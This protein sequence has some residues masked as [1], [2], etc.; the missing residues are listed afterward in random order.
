MNEY[1]VLDT[2]YH[3]SN[4]AKFGGWCIQSKQKIG[5]TLDLERRTV[6]NIIDS[7]LIKGL[8]LREEATGFLRAADI[9][10]D[11]M[12]DKENWIIGKTDEN[13]F[14]SIKQQIKEIGGEKNAP[15]VQ[16]IPQVVKNLHHDGEKNAP[17]NN[18]IYI[19][20]KGISGVK[21]IWNNFA[22]KHSLQ[23]IARV[24]RERSGK[25]ATRQKEELFDI[26]KI[27][28]EAEKQPFLFG[29][30]D[31]GW[32]MDFD[33]LIEND[34]N[35]LKILENKYIQQELQEKPL[36]VKREQ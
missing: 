32:K 31:R 2:I 27:L 18:I 33:W 1:A 8:I 28:L 3:L 15:S 29:V 17:Y 23:S 25:L 19:D 36:S 5:D 30:N 26:E 34:N 10:C 12:S 6:F 14:L 4:N 9:Y 16:E 24:S 7:L 13:A 21:E 20:K 11:C 22:V 35:Y